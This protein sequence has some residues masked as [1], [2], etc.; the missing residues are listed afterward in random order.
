MFGWLIGVRSFVVYISAMRT[1]HCHAIMK[2]NTLR[3]IN[4]GTWDRKHSM[5][6]FNSLEDTTVQ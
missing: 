3:S 5:Q 6:H 4:R 1:A 2:R